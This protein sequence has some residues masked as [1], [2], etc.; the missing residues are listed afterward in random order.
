MRHIGDAMDAGALQQAMQGVE[1]ALE[2]LDVGT[3][4]L[5]ALFGGDRFQQRFDHVAKVADA[6]DP[7]HARTTLE[8]MQV[9]LQ[10]DDRLACGGVL[11]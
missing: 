10:A 5:G 7:G 1:A 4:Q 6:G 9:A 3:A 2:Q 8:G 11:A